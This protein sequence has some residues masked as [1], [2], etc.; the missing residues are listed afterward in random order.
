[1]TSLELPYVNIASKMGRPLIK[2]EPEVVGRTFQ[3]LDSALLLASCRL[4]EMLS[5]APLGKIYIH[6][7]AI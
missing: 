7:L 5:I 2:T 1:M 6:L 4:G 3:L